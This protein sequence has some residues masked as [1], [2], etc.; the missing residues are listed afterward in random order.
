MK[1][2]VVVVT[3]A[4]AG[5]GRAIALEFARQGA[6]VGLIARSR[7]GLEKA[8]AEVEALGGSAHV[9][10]CDVTDAEGLEKAAE[11]I[12]H[13]L[14]P[15]DIWVNS[16]MATIFSWFED[17]TPEEYK[18]ATEVTYLGG[19][20]GV[21]TALKRMKPRD[22]GTIV[23]VGS[24]LAYRG[25]PLQSAYCGAKFA[26]RGFLDSVR[27]EL[28][29]Q[30]SHVKVIS[31]HLPAHDTPQFEWSLSHLDRHPQPVPPIFTPELA[32][33]AVVWAA[34]RGKRETWV[35]WPAIQTILGAR[36][37]PGA[38]LDRY[39][40]SHAVDSQFLTETVS[41]DR[42]ANLFETPPAEM[43]RTAG[44]FN[45]QA[46]DDSLA[47]RL[48]MLPRPVKALAIGAAAG[49]L[50]APM[51]MFLSKRRATD[52]EL[53]LRSKPL[54]R[55]RGAMAGNR[56]HRPWPRTARSRGS[57]VGYR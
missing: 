40:A 21:R 31:V 56:G 19:V 16:A 54:P 48:N 18:R 25:I 57:T 3:G 33:R 12:E 49:F 35:G 22:W 53:A 7:E 45:D 8:R 2:K 44:R 4:S 29:A 34:D 36:F 6:H 43:H 14:G 11:E 51:M 30:D 52:E 47:L 20:Y 9:V 50:L 15:I 37:L 24:A 13:V 1:D 27:S 39:A 10:P 46:E 5:V 32:G 28:I 38:W 26:L 23:Q 17:I 55:G 41:P 42:P